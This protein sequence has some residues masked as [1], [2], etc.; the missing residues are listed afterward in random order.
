LNWIQVA[1]YMHQRRTLCEHGTK[2]RDPQNAGNVVT[3]VGSNAFWRRAAVWR[4]VYTNLLHFYVHS[5]S[6]QVFVTWI[7][8]IGTLIA[9][10]LHLITKLSGIPSTAHSTDNHRS[11]I[12]LKYFELTVLEL[13]EQNI[14]PAVFTQPTLNVTTSPYLV[15]KQWCSGSWLPCLLAC[16]LSSSGR[17]KISQKREHLSEIKANESQTTQ[18]KGWK[19]RKEVAE[20]FIQ[21]VP[22]SNLGPRKTLA[23]LRISVSFEWHHPRCVIRS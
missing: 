21:Y 8:V 5:L 11:S 1:Q 23:K 7:T 13:S 2:L 6:A 16:V 19:H 4:H 15:S 9:I 10:L 22:T 17:R 12:F 3:T 20:T 18:P 14:L